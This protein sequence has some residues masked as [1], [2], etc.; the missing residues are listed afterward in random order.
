LLPHFGLI[1]GKHVLLDV[2]LMALVGLALGISILNLIMTRFVFNACSTNGLV[3]GLTKKKLLRDYSLMDHV[4]II[5]I[6]II[7]I[8]FLN[9]VLIGLRLIWMDLSIRSRITR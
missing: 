2:G 8:I 4:T 7:I 9:N 3:N 5:I 6:I 1:G